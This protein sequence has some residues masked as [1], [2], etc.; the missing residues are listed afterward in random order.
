MSRGGDVSF[1]KNS[2]LGWWQESN[3]PQ[4][5]LKQDP[6][7]QPQCPLDNSP[8]GT[9]RSLRSSTNSLLKSDLGGAQAYVVTAYE[10]VTI[11]TAHLMS[12]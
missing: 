1:T 6:A 10:P 2:H 5:W 9:T 11:P 8:L 12:V 4:S 7:L 3:E